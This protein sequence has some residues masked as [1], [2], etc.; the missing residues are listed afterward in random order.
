ME[1][2]THIIEG[3]F[4]L[5]VIPVA[6][7]A[8]IMALLGKLGFIKF[9]KPNR[10]KTC[11]GVGLLTTTILNLVITMTIGPMVLVLAAGWYQLP[12]TPGIGDYTIP[13]AASLKTG[14]SVALLWRLSPDYLKT[15]RR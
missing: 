4:R 1:Y 5:G 8:G 9:V 10:W 13:V 12:V 14:W 11:L 3:I 7:A 15:L 2:L 6:M